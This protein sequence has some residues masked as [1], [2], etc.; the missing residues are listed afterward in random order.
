MI[1]TNTL[2]TQL[3]F[4]KSEAARLEREIYQQKVKTAIKKSGRPI[5]NYK[6][7]KDKDLNISQA[8]ETKIE[9]WDTG[10]ISDMTLKNVSIWVCKYC[11]TPI[12]RKYI[13][14]GNHR[15]YSYDVCDCAGAKCN[16][17]KHYSKL[18]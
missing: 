3:D 5:Y 9:W 11:K 1:K 14:V 12:R 7:F 10:T 18:D 8:Y 16:G 6:D 2:K 4:H 15:D 13:S 17:G